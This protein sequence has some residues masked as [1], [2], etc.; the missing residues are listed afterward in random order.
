M[1]LL[2]MVSALGG[3]NGMIITSSRIYAEL[4]A[5]HRLFAPL[6]RW[7]R[8]WGTPVRSLVVQAVICVVMVAVVGT[9]FEGNDGFDTLVK[10]SSPVFCVFFLLTGASLIVLRRKEP[11]VERPFVTPAYPLTPLVFCAFWAFMLVGSIC[12]APAEAAVGLGIL[13]AGVPLY[14]L[15]RGWQG[16]G[17]AEEPE[18]P[19][20]PLIRDEDKQLTQC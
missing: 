17:K 10:C 8:R 4:G 20:A 18:P 14:I 5:D 12:Y 2:V 16:V 19:V 6:S 7:N 11:H 3:I 1:A 15:S 9:C 13:L